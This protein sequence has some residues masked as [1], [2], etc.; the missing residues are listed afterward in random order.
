MTS[1]DL[2]RR[3]A[4]VLLVAALVVLTPGLALARFSASSSAPAQSVGT[5]VLVAPT[6]V[7]GTYQCTSSGNT[8]GVSVTV[9]GFTDTG[10]AGSSY[11][12]TVTSEDGPSNSS[13]STAHTRTVAVSQ[14]N[15]KASTKYTVS[16]RSVYS[17]WTGPLW[18]KVVSCTKGSTNSG[19]L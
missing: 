11:A 13:T 15:D 12:V 14:T 18:S 6:S 17:N 9:S 16:I 10:P 19:S 7:T 1:L 8:E 4:T 5:A 3:A 2:S